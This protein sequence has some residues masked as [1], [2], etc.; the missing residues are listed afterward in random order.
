MSWTN[1]AIA[2]WERVASAGTSDD[3]RRAAAKGM[4]SREAKDST[5]ASAF[6][7]IPRRGVLR[8]RRS[9]TSSSGLTSSRR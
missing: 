9:E 8:M 4:R 1:A 2:A 3:R 5:A 7:P 6:S